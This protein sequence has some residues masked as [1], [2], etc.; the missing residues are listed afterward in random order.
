M[1]NKSFLACTEVDITVCIAVESNSKLKNR[2]NSCGDLDLDCK[3][4]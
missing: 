4:L 2:F 3:M 1:L